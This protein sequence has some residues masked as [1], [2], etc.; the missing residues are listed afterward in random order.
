MVKPVLIFLHGG[1]GFKDYLQRYFRELSHTFECVFYDQL[2]GPEVS[3]SSQIAQLN[4][5]V[6]RF[7]GN[8]IILVGHSWGGILAVEYLLRNP[9]IISG[10]AMISAG[11]TCK[12]WFDEYYKE[13]NNL[14]LDHAAP[15]DI[16]LTP[17]ELE[18]GVPLLKSCWETFSEETF[19]SI[20][21]NYVK[22]FDLI[23]GFSSLALPILNVFGE[24]DI[25]FPARVLRGFDR[26]NCRVANLEIPGAGHFPFL[27]E[28]NKNKIHDA[29][30]KAFNVFE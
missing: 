20:E 23:E 22:C 4:E 8:P 24:K 28:Y 18:L 2:R 29:L 9:G 30:I 19:R 16:Y 25:R 17:D 21:E 1:P 3:V 10:L 13:L 6:T 26:L 5:I 15:E 12:H 7:K 14:G 11:L 27:H